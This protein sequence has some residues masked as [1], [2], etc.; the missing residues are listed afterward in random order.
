MK[1]N[2]AQAV[3]C[4][5]PFHVV[6]LMTKAL[7]EVRRPLWQQMRQLDDVSFAKR[8]KG[9]GGHSSNALRI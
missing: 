4:I 6:A 7:D 8:F 2:A 3:I 5:D 9:A 1:Y